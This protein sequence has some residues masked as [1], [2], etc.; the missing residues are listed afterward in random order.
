MAAHVPDGTAI[1]QT[2]VARAPFAPRTVV[3]EKIRNNCL[4]YAFIFFLPLQNLQTGYMPNLGGGINFLNIGF[5]ASL[6]GALYCKGKLSHWSTVHTWVITYVAYN[7]F[8]LFIGYS[9]V[10]SDT[11]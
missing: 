1:A 2:R 5:A 10:S 8:S 11:E 9:N 4:L 7:V 3:V 6:L